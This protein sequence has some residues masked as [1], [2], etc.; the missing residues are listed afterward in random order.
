MSA[1]ELSA[2]FVQRLAELAD[3]ASH[4]IPGQVR[5]HALTL[6]E[7]GLAV[8]VDAAAEPAVDAAVRAAL[9]AGGAGAAPVPG[10]P[11]GLGPLDSAMAAATAMQVTDFDD[12]H[13]DT[14]IHPTATALAAVLGLGTTLECPGELALDS[15]VLGCEAA[16]RVGLAMP[17]HYEAGWHIS[18][19]C[20][21]LG[22]AIAASVLLRLDAARMRHALA[23]A[24]SQTTGHR[25]NFGT[26]VKPLQ[27]GRA[28][29]NGVLAALLARDGFTGP[30]RPLEGPR[31]YFRALAPDGARPAAV[32]GELGER[33]E[34]LRTTV[35]PYP[36]GVVTH[37]VIDAAGRL[38]QS[39]EP[40]RVASVEVTCHP[41]VPELTGIARPATAQLARFSTAH[42]VAVA[43]RTAT[44][45][46]DAYREPT[47]REPA[48]AA[49]RERV[50]LLPEPGRA[51][52]S[53]AVRV[54]LD[55]GR[56]YTCDVAACVGSPANPMDAGQVAAKARTLIEARMP[57]RAGPIHDAVSALP[58]AASMAQ[59]AAA[60][61]SA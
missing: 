40:A 22:A 39:V 14:V 33:W 47:W 1:P 7:N 52:E 58:R 50:T 35:K 53:A 17:G 9:E 27:V 60:L 57:G 34:L 54:V 21:V 29:A 3:P 42:A 38:A 8:A 48:V 11:E 26:D 15:F 18:S 4:G 12:N 44:V 2:Q 25:A 51:K 41:L 56:D 49:I 32:C 24:A 13:L 28:A 43:L 23:I 37:P 16:L 30:A 55:D 36:C 20:G 46:A 10:R 45:T 19:S 5:A 59:L 61:R 6:I 31:G